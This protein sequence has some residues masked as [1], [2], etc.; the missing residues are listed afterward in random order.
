MLTSSQQGT[1][2]AAILADSQ[3]NAFPNTTD[4]NFDLAVFLGGL[5][6]PAFRVWRTN[7]PTKDVKNAIVWTEYIARSQGERDAF[8]L[9]I[10]NGIINGADVNI[11]QGI[12]DIFSGPSG[13]TT[14]TNL[15]AISKRDATRIEKILA[16]GTGSDASPAT[17]TYEGS[18]S[19]TDVAAARNSA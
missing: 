3:L 10:S 1:L 14:R 13:A 4:G 16:T 18:I 12:Q 6:S 7:V 19:G 15:T 11:R 5:A 8:V 17:M 2:K 9:M